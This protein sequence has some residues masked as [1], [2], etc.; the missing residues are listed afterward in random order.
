MKTFTKLTLSAI[1]AILVMGSTAFG[2]IAQRGTATSGTA[3]TSPLTINKPAGVIAG[4]VMLVNIS[5]TGNNTTAATLAGWTSVDARSLAGTTLRYATVLYRVADGTEGASFAFTLGAGVNS[6]VGS[7]VAFS[8]V[9][10]NGVKADGS[11]GGPFDVDPGSISVQ[12]NSSIVTATSINTASANAAVVM[13]GQAGGDNPTWSNW[14]TA[15]S[16]G[17][18]TE[19]YDNQN[20]SG[21]QTTVGAAWATKAA[22][23][24]TGAGDADLSANERNGAI[25]VA[26]KRNVTPTATLSPSTTRFILVGASV[27]FTATANNYVGSGN[28]SYTW[29]ASG[30]SIPGANP[31]VTAGSSDTKSLTYL[32]PGVYPVSVTIARTGST[33][34]TT[35]ITTVVVSAVPT[36][37]NLWATSSNGTQ[38]STFTVANG[39]YFSGPTNLFAPTFPGG[40]TGGTT[41]AALG[42]NAQGGVANGFYYWLPNTSGN[43]GV[44]EIFAATSTG[45]S[46]TR[47]GSVDVNGGNTNSLGFVRL[48]MGP[49]GSGW[50]LAGDNTNLYLAKFVSNGVN[51]VTLSTVPVILAGGNV[52]TFQN[53]DV[54]VAGD[55]TMYALAN[56]GG[57]VTQIFKGSLNGAS[58][59]LT[60]RWDLV[61][62]TNAPFTGSVNGVAFDQLG[63]LYVSTAAGLYYIDQSTVNG[64]AGTVE[65]DLVS[66][67]TGL[68]DL[69]SNFFPT[70]STLPVNLVSFMGSYKSQKTTLIWETENMSN[71]KHFEIQ[72]S[73]TGNDYATIGYKNPQ[74]NGASRIQYQYVDDL[75]GNNA[76]VFYYRLKMVDIDGNFKYSNVI[77]IRKIQKGAD[78]VVNPNPVRS[79]VKA[80]A[81]FT[82]TANSKVTFSII[83]A[84][85]KVV[86]TQQNNVL[87]GT[88][89]VTLN[90]LDR[91]Q[92]GIYMVRMNDGE[93]TTTAKIYI[94]H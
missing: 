93:I 11:A 10:S 44:V 40:T 2:Q 31:N 41:T 92:S 81:N 47:I 59:T 33:T 60:K 17:V 76:G 28:Y 64:P 48:G 29:H 36:S 15:T 1:V 89:T 67:V 57:G 23:G 12:G 22:A 16:P 88:N 85:G 43:G 20:A 78:L 6:A 35:A 46:H 86:L 55:N 73:T 80:T 5:Q 65:C 69:A 14:S 66:A 72:R 83:D 58:V 79:G 42:R 4:D 71:F 56:D 30:A 75:S 82:A 84:S 49:D 90:N 74:G 9:A 8:G 45:A 51:L 53:G 54:C 62:P 7:I 52:S 77:V 24:S 18:L 87:Q 32:T 34:L 50:I 19:L 39:T 25:L 3:T 26:L 91:L 37:P 21:D 70:G 68:Q 94:V 13:L 61:D 38:V 63:S 27:S